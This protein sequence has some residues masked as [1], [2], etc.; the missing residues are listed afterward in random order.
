VWAKR[1][2]TR[3]VE[4]RAFSAASLNGRRSQ[5]LVDPKRDLTKIG[6]TFGNSDSVERADAPEGRA[7]VKRRPN[8]LRR[9]MNAD[10]AVRRLLASRA[11]KKVSSRSSEKTK[12][13]M[14]GSG[15]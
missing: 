7:L 4:V 11:S 3:D 5:A 14:S 1:Y 6:Y 15:D 12:K 2:G 9:T 10:P 8:A 13:V